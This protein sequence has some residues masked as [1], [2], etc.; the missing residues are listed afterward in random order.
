[1]TS[2][3]KAGA[4]EASRGGGALLG[5][6]INAIPVR[7]PG[8]QIAGI[9]ALALLGSLL[10]SLSTN[11]NIEHAAITEYFFF[12]TLLDGLKTTIILTI[13][14]E[15]LGIVVG[16]S[17]AIMRLSA[18][19][20]LSGISWLYIWYFRGVPLIVQ[21]LIWGN[22]A[23]LFQHLVIGIPFTD[24]WILS[25]DTNAIV[26]R[27][28]ASVL[29]LGLTEAAY[30]AEIVRAGILSV[31]EGQTEAA[32]SLGFTR[33][34]MLRKI[35]LPQAL[36]VIIPPTGNNLISMMKNT[37]LV[38]V[39]AGGDLLTKA[40]GLYSTNLYTIEIL[41]I[42]SCYYLALTSA[43]SVGQYYLERRFARG[44]HRTLPPTPVGRLRR[45]WAARRSRSAA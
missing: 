41:A 38:V 27:F 31:D 12:P 8:R 44:A 26:T 7:H 42:A 21:L 13:A 3:E 33:G 35:I 6:E 28:V 15:G 32:Q 5:A 1:M 29:G 4:G 14:A 43:A 9:I 36:R 22:L 23:L 11:P 25:G 34:Q 24:L 19:P 10:V 37:S 20:V 40:Q 45:S 17:V 39:I 2:T 16:T 18:N 30:Y